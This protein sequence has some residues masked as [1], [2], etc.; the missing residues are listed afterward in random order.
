MRRL[1]ASLLIA[2]LPSVSAAQL[3]GTTQ[4]NGS[5]SLGQ[6]SGPPVITGVV[7]LA[8]DTT[9]V[10]AFNTNGFATPWMGC[11]TSPDT[12]TAHTSADA[13]VGTLPAHLQG[14]SGLLPSTVYFC[15][16]TSTTANGSTPFLFSVST[17]STPATTAITSLTLGAINDYNSININNQGGADTFYN[18]KSNDGVTYMVNDDSFGFT[19]NGLPTYVAG[20]GA[21]NVMKV[22]SEAPLTIQTINNFANYGV[23]SSLGDSLSSKAFGIFCMNGILFLDIGRQNQSGTQATGGLAQ[24]HGNIIWSYDHGVT[25]NY[26]QNIG[27]F[28]PKGTTTNP[29]TFS[30]WPGSPATMGSAAFVKYGADNGTLGYTDPINQHDNGNIYVYLVF[31]EGTWNGGG[32]QGGGNVLYIAR[33]P[34]A[35]LQNLQGTDWQWWTG[36]DGNLDSNWSFSES[37]A[38]PMLSNTGKL[39]TPDVVYIPS[40]N[41]YLMLT[42]YYPSGVTNGGS[43]LDSVWLAYEAPH[44]WG[45]WTQVF[46]QEFGGANGGDYNPIILSDTAFSGNTVTVLWTQNYAIQ[47]TDYVMKFSTFVIN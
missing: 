45:P 4:L 31:N 16:I 32:S 27:Q 9:I 35:K 5:T 33:V 21:Q 12:F 19:I 40:K 18:C 26:P 22:L 42:F 29:L 14:V 47:P 34:R 3:A 7:S 23:A 17:T 39:G 10:A 15:E 36:G 8:T 38:T 37:S 6:P 30:M 44:P 2:L 20:T 28:S 1:L 13:G 46:S 25:W 43:N 24:L 41:R 11:N